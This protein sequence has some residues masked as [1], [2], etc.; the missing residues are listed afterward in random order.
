MIR[1]IKYSDRE[2][3]NDVENIEIHDSDVPQ[4]G[5]VQLSENAKAV[6][7]MNPKFMTYEKIDD[8][9]I[10]VEIEKGC[11]KA[12]YSWMSQNN[13]TNNNVQKQDTAG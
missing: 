2:L 7:R 8:L 5:D 3:E 1:N 4:Y 10:E 11:T 12:R 9:S 6:L 13:G